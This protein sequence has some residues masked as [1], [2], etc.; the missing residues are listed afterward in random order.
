MRIPTAIAAAAI[1]ALAATSFAAP[2][3][4]EQEIVDKYLKKTE[5]KHAMEKLSWLS[6]HFT[7]DRVNRNNDYNSFTNHVNNNLTG[8]AF[9]WLDQTYAIGGEF[10]MMFEK[11]FAWKL[12]GEYW[13]KVGETIEG[14]V[15]YSPPS[16]GTPVDLV[17]PQSEMKVIGF[18]G[19]VDYFLL[20]PP[21][22]KQELAGPSVKIGG[23]VGYYQV[24]WDLFPQS[25]NLNLSTATYD[26]TN[27]AFKGNAPGFSL[28]AGVD[29]PVG[30][31]GLSLCGEASYFYLNF[32]NVAWYNSADQ[33]VVASYNEQ[34]DGRVDLNFSGVRGRIALKR[35]FSL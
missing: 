34:P 19:G 33:E 2:N 12:G 24:N 7:V 35:Y 22:P 25:Q 10:G 1:I 11:K 28:N 6:A 30:A 16:G 18:Y 5:K 3:P 23:N 4:T 21:A 29:Y 20:N 17:N 31:F 8:G 27:A 32:T 9:S 14:T 13:L 26:G 15:T